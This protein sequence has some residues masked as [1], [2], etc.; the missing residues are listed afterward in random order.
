MY[1][2]DFK[3]AGVAGDLQAALELMTENGLKLDE[4][5]P[6]GQY[7]GCALLPMELSQ[8]QVDDRMKLTSTLL[9]ARDCSTYGSADGAPPPKANTSNGQAKAPQA[10][11][12]VS[13]PSNIG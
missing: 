4:P 1:V 13:G 10:S 8:Q 7:L 6:F 11:H 12:S 2:G 3:F 9:T 5:Q